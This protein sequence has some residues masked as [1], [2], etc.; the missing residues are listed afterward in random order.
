LVIDDAIKCIPVVGTIVGCLV[1]ATIDASM[2]AY[3]GKKAKNYFESK[4]RNDD[5]TVFFCNRCYEYEIIFNKFKNFDNY[6][7]IYPK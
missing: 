4:C 6:D 1:G 7:I 3:Y 2:I 5:G